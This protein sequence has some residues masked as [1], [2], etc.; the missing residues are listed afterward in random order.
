[1]RAT[2]AEKRQVAKG[3]VFV[4]FA[5]EDYPD[6]RPG[7]YFWV[8]LPDRGHHDEKGLR[9]HISLATSPTER[10]VVGLATRLRDTAF[11][12]HARRA[13]GR[14][15][16]AGG[17]AEGLVPAPGG[18]GARSTSSSPA[19]SASPSSARCSASSPTGR[20]RTGSRSSTRTATAS[21]RR[22]S[23][24]WRSSSERIDGLTRDPDDDRRAGL[25][26]GDPPPRRGR[27]RRARRRA[28]GED[29][30]RRR[31]AADGRGGGA[32]RSAAP[33]SPRNACSST[34]SP[35]TERA[36]AGDGNPEC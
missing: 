36:T 34:V 26:G 9:R 18:H 12:Q 22:S 5:V 6:Y 24:S 7:S 17:G 25:G 20:C 8:E 4:R 32:S 2:V 23:T 16:G 31:P 30:P 35:A 14:R 10:G 27:A 15:R 13:R 33:G 11:K 28:R 29:V 21:R 19:A 1:M 3:T